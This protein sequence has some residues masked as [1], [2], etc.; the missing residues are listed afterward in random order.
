MQ[1]NRP[2][3]PHERFSQ[4]SALRA[5]GQAGLSNPRLLG[6]GRNAVFMCDQGIAK[7]YPDRPTD[8]QYLSEQ[9][10]LAR[11]MADQG[12]RVSAPLSGEPVRGEGY[13]LVFWQ[14]LEGAPGASP[15]ALAALLSDFHVAG[16]RYY[17]P[18][19]GFDYLEKMDYRLRAIVD[20]ELIS[21]FDLS[22]F[23]GFLSEMSESWDS[24]ERV[25]G[26]GVIHGDAH[27][28]NVIT[29]PSGAFLIDFDW[30][31]RSDRE[32]DLF[33]ICDRRYTGSPDT[34]SRFFDAYGLDPDAYPRIGMLEELTLFSSLSLLIELRAR[35]CR[36]E[37]E[38]RLIY[39]RSGRDP[40][41][42]LWSKL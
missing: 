9:I 33:K 15:E 39:F 6:I 21:D 27:Q 11:F 10:N 23:E 4:E 18:L 12:V 7:F 1:P 32:A 36:E 40:S 3:L 14:A 26:E 22:V 31:S 20:S 37:I 5:A 41:S 29:T 24:A 2:L 30:V 25:L 34:R 42:P 38:R 8:Y 17:S 28:A 13:K 19:P 35:E 16:E